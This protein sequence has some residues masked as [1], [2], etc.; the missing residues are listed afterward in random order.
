MV[1]M[2]IPPAALHSK[3]RMEGLDPIYL[4]NPDQPAPPNSGEVAADTD[5]DSNGSSYDS[6]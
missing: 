4:D 2:G 3:M 5:S 1:H 6:D